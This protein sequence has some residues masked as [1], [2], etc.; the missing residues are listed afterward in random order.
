[1]NAY[2]TKSKPNPTPKYF[3]VPRTWIEAGENRRISLFAAVFFWYLVDL[4]SLAKKHHETW[5]DQYG[6]YSWLTL[7]ETCRLFGVKKRK[8]SAISTELKKAGLIIIDYGDGGH[9]RRFRIPDLE[10]H[11]KARE[12]DFFQ[13]PYVLLDSESY[14]NVSFGAKLIYILFYAR[15]QRAMNRSDF[16]FK[17]RVYITYTVRQIQSDLSFSSAKVTKCLRELEKSHLIKRK[18]QQLQYPDLIFVLNPYSEE[19]ENSRHSFSTKRPVAIDDD[20]DDFSEESDVSEQEESA[21]AN[22]NEESGDLPENEEA[23]ACEQSQETADN[24]GCDDTNRDFEVVRAELR[25]RWRADILIR[26]YDH[27]NFGNGKMG[28]EVIPLID[29]ILD[30]AAHAICSPKAQYRIWRKKMKGADVSKILASSKIDID[31]LIYTLHQ[32]ITTTNSG[33]SFI[34]S[35]LLT[36][37]KIIITTNAKIA[38]MSKKTGEKTRQ[39]IDENMEYAGCFFNGMYEEPSEE[40]NEIVQKYFA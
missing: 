9:K 11:L 24:D 40:Y 30:E 3:R 16:C 36:D 10:K 31:T 21:C 20:F 5:S 1:M 37:R 4:M 27:D 7:P 33:A 35:T 22:E 23:E 26:L 12:S 14:A 2:F 28:Q 19:Y 13:F 6:L 38:A 8:A 29:A 18:K 34:I 15:N 17:D 39:N 25:R 32:V